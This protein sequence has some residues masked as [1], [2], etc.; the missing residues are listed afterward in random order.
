MAGR[1]ST[2]RP[3]TW[4]AILVSVFLLGIATGCSSDKGN[5]YSSGGGG[6]GNPGANEVWIQNMAFNPTSRTVSAG[7]TVTWTN[8]D[9]AAHTVT[10]SGW[11]SGNIS[12]NAT[13]AHTF[14]TAGS[15]SYHCTIHPSMTGTITVQ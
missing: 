12:Q 8:K 11:G 4:A 15:Y 14:A 1:H 3:I 5:P 13:F 7:T 6:G 10:G 2:F 9:A